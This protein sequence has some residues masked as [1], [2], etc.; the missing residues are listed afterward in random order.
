MHVPS[1]V[2]IGLDCLQN[3]ILAT[4]I[5]DMRMRLTVVEIPSTCTSIKSTA[6]ITGRIVVARFYVAEV[7]VDN[8]ACESRQARSRRRIDGRHGASIECRNSRLIGE[9]GTHD[10]R[11]LRAAFNC[12][13]N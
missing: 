7:R 4:S 3:F 11:L 13:V 9:K 8:E 10:R 5:I 2:G 6:W 12:G 1:P